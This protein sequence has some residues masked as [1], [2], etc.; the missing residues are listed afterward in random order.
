MM[1]IKYYAPIWIL[2]AGA[3]RARLFQYAGFG[4]PLETIREWEHPESRAKNHDLVT[5][6]PG[7]V[8]QSRVGPH[9]GH[10]SRSGM[11]P[12]LPAKEV[13]HEHF[14][15]QLTQELL[16]NLNQDAYE[17]LIMI[18]SPDFLGMLRSLA[19]ERVLKRTIACLDKDYTSLTAE[20]LAQNLAPIFHA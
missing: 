8:M 9:P 19:S 10:G 6:R 12:R 2:V 7:R 20:D 17:Q 3:S 4:R 11:E 1:N 5:D 16:T 15:R 14:A 18:A 13:E